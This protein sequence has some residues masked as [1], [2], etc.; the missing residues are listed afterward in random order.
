[1]QATENLLKLQT[2]AQRRIQKFKA[3]YKSIPTK[4][5]FDGKLI[6]SHIALE[7]DNLNI[8][9]LREF[10]VST[11]RQARTATGLP[12]IVNQ[13][14][15]KEGEIGAY[16]LSVLNTVKY[17]KLK[18]PASIKRTEEP[19]IRNP[20]ET[21]K[22]LISCGASNLPS[23]QKALA[24]NTNLFRDLAPIR[25]FYAH[26]CGDTFQKV[27]LKASSLGVTKI[28]HPDELLN[29]IL[30]GRPHS[31]LEDWL[32]DAEIFYDLLME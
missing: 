17:T 12:I 29:N 9:T 24:L 7:L 10:T 3:A 27:C 1:M 30:V 19:T 22:I 11:L 26:R 20:K 18:N 4:P 8:S 15:E 16:I 32:C 5:D 21:E 25:H 28:R 14:F 31:I 2:A 23:L 6:L 13:K